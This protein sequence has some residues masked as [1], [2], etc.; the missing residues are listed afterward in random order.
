MGLEDVYVLN[1]DYHFRNDNDRVVMYSYNKTREYS[2]PS[3]LGFIHPVQA[4][5]LALFTDDKQLKSHLK[6][7]SSYFHLSMEEALEI[8]KPYINNPNEIFT[9]IGENSVAFPKNVLIPLHNVTNAEYDF[10]LSDLHCD[11]INLTP[12]RTHKCPQYMLFMLTNK[13]VTNCKYC[14]ADRKTTSVE[15]ELEQIMQVLDEAHKLKM[16]Q[17]DVIGGEVFCK[18][19]WDI[20]LKKLIDYRMAPTYISTKVPITYKIANQLKNTG[21]NDIVQI[22]LDSLDD[23]VLRELIGVTP[24]YSNRIRDGI[25]ILRE[26]GFKIQIDTVLTKLNCS[27]STILQ[28]YNYIKSVKKLTMWEIRV[29][30]PSIYSQISF[31]EVKATREELQ[32]ICNFVKKEILPHSQLKILVSD[33]DLTQNYR[34][35]DTRQ[36]YFPKGTCGILY[37]R[38]FVLPDGKVSVCEQL[39]NHP[40]F[41][42]GDLTRQSIEEVWNSP[43]ASALFNF[44][45]E[46]LTPKSPCKKCKALDSCI[47]NK[48]KC[49]VRSIQAYGREHWD[50]PD[51]YCEKAPEFNAYFGY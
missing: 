34:K 26:F 7:I 41:I 31:S 15:M 8:I 3:W 38:F 43:R 9:G 4:M 46:E 11:R 13:C 45:K 48:R 12:D 22:S 33:E 24:G 6:D 2:N 23:C 35:I 40:Q 14:Y 29:P 32:N 30:S 16:S 27:E 5:L 21:Y 44:R 25:S 51:P 18:Q 47:K 49:F 50:F 1:P 20:I 19:G 36:A 10:N 39:Y 37:N 28:L 17:V 42:I